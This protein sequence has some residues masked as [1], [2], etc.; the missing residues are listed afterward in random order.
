MFGMNEMEAGDH[1]MITITSPYNELVKE[2]GV[3]LVY[4]DREEDAFGY[5]KS[6][7]NIIGGVPT[8]R[9]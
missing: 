3:S 5:Y 6:S 4:N 1:V 2:C 7:K 8:Q 9:K